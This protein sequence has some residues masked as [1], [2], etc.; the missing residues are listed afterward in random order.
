MSAPNCQWEGCDCAAA[1]AFTVRA[2]STSRSPASRGKTVTSLLCV[3]H[4]TIA[5]RNIDGEA[6]WLDEDQEDEPVPE[7]MRSA[8]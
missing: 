3:D 8:S 7:T 4:H 6:R 2:G 1:I 5:A